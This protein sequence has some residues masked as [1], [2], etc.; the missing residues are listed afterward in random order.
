[1]F[2]ATTH[3]DLVIR[4][5]ELKIPVRMIHNASIMN[6]IGACG[7]QLYKF[8][9]T[10]SLVFFENNYRPQSFYD[11][12]KENVSLGLHTLVLLGKLID[13]SSWCSD[14]KRYQG[15]GAKLGK[16]CSRQESIRTSSLYVC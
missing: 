1:M 16:S 14:N 15:K 2:R 9:Q 3:A 5:R 10:V 12:I 8:G 7:L 13:Y 4:A 6:A 11:H